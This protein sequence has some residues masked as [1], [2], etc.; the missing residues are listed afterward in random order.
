MSGTLLKP[1]VITKAN[2]GTLITA[3]W[4]TKA[5]ICKGVTGA[6]APAACR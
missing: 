4:A 6:S 2:L 3:K 5:E 1:V